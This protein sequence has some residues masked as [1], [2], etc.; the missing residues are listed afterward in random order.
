M[1][2]KRSTAKSR[3]CAVGKDKHTTYQGMVVRISTIDG[4]LS[5]MDGG[6]T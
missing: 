4:Q 5:N 3:R 1:A 6:R 2:A